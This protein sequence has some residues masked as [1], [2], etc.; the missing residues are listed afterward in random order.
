MSVGWGDNGFQW[1]W[2]MGLF[3][4]VVAV[5]A[6]A[7]FLGVTAESALGQQG[8]TDAERV[9]ALEQTIRTNGSMIPGTNGAYICSE[10]KD[11]TVTNVI[12]YETGGVVEEK[13]L[14]LWQGGPRKVGLVSPVYNLYLQTE[15][16]SQG[17]GGVS[18]KST[19]D[20]I[21][22]G[23]ET[24][25]SKG[26]PLPTSVL[27]YIGPFEFMT[28]EERL[29]S[30]EEAVRIACK[31]KSEEPSYPVIVQLLEPVRYHM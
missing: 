22:E 5:A 8:L 20:V 13:I 18:I 23:Q 7:C 14:T 21:P 3:Q 4:R 10:K 27:P 15:A 6:G 1:G 30:M 25:L 29:K 16:T 12:V 9:R 19:Y 24:P 31:P 11:L 26:V 2:G 28:K 17:G